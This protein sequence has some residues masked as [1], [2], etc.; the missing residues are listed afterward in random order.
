M[1][2]RRSVLGL[3]VA[4]V[5][6]AGPTAAVAQT[7]A[8]TPAAFAAAQQAGRPILVHITASWCSVCAAQ[9]PILSKLESDPRFRALTVFNVDFDSQKAIVRGFGARAQ[10]TLI[11]FKGA[12]ETGRS[13]GETDPQAIE[14][15]LAKT[16]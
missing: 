5:L 1:L 14:A 10:S 4:A 3:L 9:K 16:I 13:T 11:T 8:Y 6:L 15:L 7:L 2:P 12:A